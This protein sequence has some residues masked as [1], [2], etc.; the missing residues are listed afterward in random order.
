MYLGTSPQATSGWTGLDWTGMMGLVTLLVPLYRAF[1]RP[2]TRARRKEKKSSQDAGK[3]KEDQ[4]DVSMCRCPLQN[5]KLL[6]LHGERNVPSQFY[7]GKYVTLRCLPSINNVPFFPPYQSAAK[8]QLRIHYVFH[9]QPNIRL[10]WAVY[11]S[12]PDPCHVPR[13]MQCMYFH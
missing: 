10:E 7:I 9:R 4:G 12:S 13:S 3:R 8:R 2:I 1:Q 11:L 6:P 5:G